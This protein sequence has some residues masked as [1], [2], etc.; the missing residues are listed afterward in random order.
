MKGIECILPRG[1]NRAVSGPDGEPA[2]ARWDTIA[3]HIVRGATIVGGFSTEQETR[4]WLCDFL[5]SSPCGRE[6]EI[7]DQEIALALTM[8]LAFRDREDRLCFGC[9]RFREFVC[10]RHR[11]GTSKHEIIARLKRAAR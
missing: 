7:E 9:Q 11:P 5:A 10:S 3:L 6:G 2:R 8:G 4:E 1:W